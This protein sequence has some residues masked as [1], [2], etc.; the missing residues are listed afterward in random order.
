M[1]KLLIG[2]L[3]LLLTFGNGGAA[4]WDFQ[5]ILTGQQMVPTG[6][7]WIADDQKMYFG[8]D[9]DSYI[10]YDTGTGAT[11][12]SGITA[13]LDAGATIASGEDLVAAGGDTI[14]NFGPASGAFTTSTGTNTLSGNV[15]VAGSKT[16]TT[17]TG[18]VSILGN[19][20]IPG[21]KIFTMGTGAA[22]FGGSVTSASL[23]SNTTITAT[24]GLIGADIWLSDDA[25]IVD[26]VFI[27]GTLTAADLVTN[28]TIVGGST[29]TATTGLIGADLWTSDDIY[30]V[31][32][33]N[34]GGDAVA[35]TITSNGTVTATTSLIGADVRA[36]DDLYIV[37]GANIGGSTTLSTVYV[38]G[39]SDI[40]HGVATI[41][42]VNQSSS[43]LTANVTLVSGTVKP[44]YWL[45]PASAN[46]GMSIVLPPVAEMNNA[47]VEFSVKTA[48][49]NDCHIILDPS[50][51]EKINNAATKYATAK[52]ATIKLKCDG[53]EWYILSSSLTWT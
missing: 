3:I 5:K 22:T 50:G 15:V 29:V 48:V 20:I 2:L 53:S 31:D 12:I 45:Q 7:P 23:A 40:S 37:D 17:G 18:L 52:Y 34:V 26:D 24:T 41:G 35:A 25:Y 43:I 44:F 30:T 10:E 9:K 28:S 11:V 46:V 42:V 16:T 1:K 39:T 4:Y 19:M 32:D 36:T 27:N 14:F 51:S 13:S 6:A 21:T 8:T 49:T 33:L 47:T 38:N